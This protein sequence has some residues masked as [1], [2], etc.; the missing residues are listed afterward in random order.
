[1]RQKNL[2][3]VL[4]F[5]VLTVYSGHAATYYLI[6]SGNITNKT[7]WNTSPLNTGAQPANFT[8][9]G[10]VWIFQS[11]A[12]NGNRT[13]GSITNALF[14]VSASAI[15][16]I[17]SGFNLTLSSNGIINGFIDVSNG[18]ILTISNGNTVKF[19][20]LGATSTVIFNSAL[21]TVD[22]RAYGNLTINQSLSL[23]GSG[24]LLDVGGLLTLATGITFNINSKDV[25]LGGSAGLIAGT[26]F[27]TGTASSKL[28]LVGG[29]G[30]NNGTLYFLTGNYNL[31]ELEMNLPLASDY[32]TLGNDLTIVNGG[33]AIYYGTLNLN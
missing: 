3:S 11:N 2:L 20:T 9:A 4:L 16:T 1:M 22:T 24:T 7:N 29:N 12:A 6:S 23:S 10:D 25:S 31:K 28:S 30:G 26:G 21:Q 27:L 19:G 32:I 17:E 8:G 5:L 33:V 15:V 18:G 14:N 13:A